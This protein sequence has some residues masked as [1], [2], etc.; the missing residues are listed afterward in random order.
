M[1]LKIASGNGNNSGVAHPKKM[2]PHLGALAIFHKPSHTK[3][4]CKIAKPSKYC[5][6]FSKQ[7]SAE[8]NIFSRFWIF[9]SWVYPEKLFID[10]LL[11]T[12][13]AVIEPRW[14]TSATQ[15]IKKVSETPGTVSIVAKLCMN[16]SRNRKIAKK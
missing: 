4:L 5:F 11:I 1:Y 7:G 10:F 12:P 14:A 16:D 2:K 15:K 13:Q 8:N 9:F 6:S 3:G